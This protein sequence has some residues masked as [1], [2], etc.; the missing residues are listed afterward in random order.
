MSVYLKIYIYILYIIYLC[1]DRYLYPF[2][3]K[4]ILQK[5]PPFLCRNRIQVQVMVTLSN[6]DEEKVSGLR[7][8]GWRSDPHGEAGDPPIPKAIYILRSFQTRRGGTGI[9]PKNGSLVGKQWNLDLKNGR[10]IQV[11]DL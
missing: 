7:E 4:N 8:K 3:G 10:N 11:K 2:L 6:A 1:K 5:N 9:P